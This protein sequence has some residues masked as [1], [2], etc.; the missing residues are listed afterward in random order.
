M[1]ESGDK[2]IPFSRAYGVR[3][4]LS[5]SHLRTKPTQKSGTLVVQSLVFHWKLKVCQDR[6][7][8]DVSKTLGRYF[9][10]LSFRFA[11][12]RDVAVER[13]PDVSAVLLQGCVPVP[14]LQH[15]TE[16]RTQSTEQNTEQSTEHS[17]EQNTQNTAQNTAQ[18]ILQK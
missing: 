12:N 4:S 16:H 11:P 15:S 13:V 7:G 3:G 17:T 2:T 14:H 10:P 9:R 18:G 8:T 5:L 1:Q 6:L